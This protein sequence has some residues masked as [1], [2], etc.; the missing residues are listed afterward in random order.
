MP[1]QNSRWQSLIQVAPNESVTL[2]LVRRYLGTLT[3]EELSRLPTDCRPSLPSSREEV[4]TW[5]VQLVTKQM[6]YTGERRAADLLHQMAI[7]FSEANTRF[8]QLAQD[9]RPREQPES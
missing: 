3:D 5:A 1:L 9:S 4:A 7:V 8:A 6:K 2:A